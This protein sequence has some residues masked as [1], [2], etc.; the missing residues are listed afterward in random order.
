MDE[1]LPAA[2]WLVISLVVGVVLGRHLAGTA[3]RENP[4]G[5]S[6]RSRAIG[7]CVALAVFG[8]YTAAELAGSGATCGD[9]KGP[10]IV[11]FAP[12]AIT[13]VLYALPATAAKMRGS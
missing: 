4:Y 11:L 2:V 13:A 5:I 10:G 12:L 3:L 7:M 1:T 9:Y 6:A 8:G